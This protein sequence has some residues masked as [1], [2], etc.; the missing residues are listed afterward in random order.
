MILKDLLITVG[1]YVRRPDKRLLIRYSMKLKGMTGLEIGGPSPIFSLKGYFP[2]YLFA[3]NIDGVNYSTNT[4]WEGNIKEGLN[5]RFYNKIGFQYIKEATNLLQI[6]A[7]KYD[8]ILSSHSL[9][10][11]ANPLKALEQWSRI[12]KNGG[13][14][15]L[16]LP[17]KKYT[18]DINRAYTSIE[19]LLDD[20][21]NDVSEKD[22]THFNEVIETLDYEKNTDKFTKESILK[23]VN[24][25]YENRCVHHHVFSFKLIEEMLSRASFEVLYQKELSPHHLFTIAKKV[26]K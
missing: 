12:L 14:F 17:N 6:E 26:V 7:N 15:V 4:V 5:F 22:N 10:H 13:Y 21:N 20:Y 11:I 18:Y 16:V 2:V 24:N 3:K 25:N 9:E 1:S 19:H 23:D 8:F